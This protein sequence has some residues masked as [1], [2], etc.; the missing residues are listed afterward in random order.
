MRS[1]K[2]RIFERLMAKFPRKNRLSHEKMFV[3]CSCSVLRDAHT[4][5]HPIPIIDQPKSTLAQFLY[6]RA[7]EKTAGSAGQH[8]VQK[9]ML[10]HVPRNSSWIILQRREGGVAWCVCV[11]LA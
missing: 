1:L 11:G 5:A 10:T 7:R 4:Y 9:K 2:H 8:Y 3:S 6:S